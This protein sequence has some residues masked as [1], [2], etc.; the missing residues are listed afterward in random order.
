MATTTINR[1]LDPQ[2][3]KAIEQM[4]DKELKRVLRTVHPEFFGKQEEKE[5]FM[6]MLKNLK[7]I[8]PK[9]DIDECIRETRDQDFIG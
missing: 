1:E 4:S 3:R 6:T 5:D 2:V 8:K 7:P 9:M